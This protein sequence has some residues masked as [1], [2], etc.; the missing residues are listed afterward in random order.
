MSVSGR[1]ITHTFG[2]TAF[3]GSSSTKNSKFK[4]YGD[5]NPYAGSKRQREAEADEYGSDGEII[6][7]GSRR[8]KITNTLFVP[9]LP[10]D[11]PDD[12]KARILAK[13]YPSDAVATAAKVNG[14]ALNGNVTGTAAAKA[15]Y[16]GVN[17]ASAGGDEEDGAMQAE[18]E[19]I[20]ISDDNEE[21]ESYDQEDD[22]DDI[23]DK[24]ATD[25]KLSDKKSA[26]CP[27]APHD[28]RE[29]SLRLHIPTKFLQQAL[30]SE[31]QDNYSRLWLAAL[32]CIKNQQGESSK[33]KKNWW[34]NA[35]MM[36]FDRFGGKKKFGVNSKGKCSQSDANVRSLMND[37]VDSMDLHLQSQSITLEAFGPR[38]APASANSNTAIGKPKKSREGREARKG[39]K[40]AALS[41]PTATTNTT[42]QLDEQG[43]NPDDDLPTGTIREIPDR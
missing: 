41:V 39:R 17:G 36:L 8:R 18:P 13:K 16:G 43:G 29:K 33:A 24:R 2:V 31:A 26:A 14:A 7:E 37:M 20:K 1:P 22:E 10:P 35:K 19:I 28:G 6:P 25:P 11:M 21:D 40:R 12:M 38:S 9:S 34:K 4:L 42:T 3:G 27:T 32:C 23:D 15:I 30:Q 5:T